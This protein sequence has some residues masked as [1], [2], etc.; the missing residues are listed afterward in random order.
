MDKV[1]RAFRNSGF[2]SASSSNRDTIR[3]TALIF[4]PPPT[5]SQGPLPQGQVPVVREEGR[6]EEKGVFKD[7]HRWAEIRKEVMVEGVSW[8]QLMEEGG[9]H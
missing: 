3:Q 6:R 8:F 2:R 1:S 7:M 4:I 5:P 9:I